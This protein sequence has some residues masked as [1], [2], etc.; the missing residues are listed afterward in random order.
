MGSVTYLSSVIKKIFLDEAVL[1]VFID[2]TFLYG[3][4][5]L[6]G[7]GHDRSVEETISKFPAMYLLDWLLWPPVQFINF[8]FLPLRYRVLYVNCMNL[9]WSTILS[10][11][12]HG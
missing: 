11:F 6:E 12:K 5:I 1:S 9:I 8:F 10:W 4:T 3:V 2:G 7:K